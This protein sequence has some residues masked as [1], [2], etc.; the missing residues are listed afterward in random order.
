M[1]NMGILSLMEAIQPKRQWTVWTDNRHLTTEVM[2]R[3]NT[4]K[5]YEARCARR[6]R[7]RGST[8]SANK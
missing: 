3:Y 2:K 7:L 8:G 5:D 4:Q 6:R 1:S